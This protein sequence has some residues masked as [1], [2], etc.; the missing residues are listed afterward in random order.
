MSEYRKCKKKK[1]E[2]K[3]VISGIKKKL[4]LFKVFL[5]FC[6]STFPKGP[7]VSIIKADFLLY[8]FLFT[9]HIQYV[10]V[11]AKEVY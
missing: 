9:L 10:Y 11:Y 4:L 7:I 8:L 5:L 6:L 1:V 3:L 2:Y